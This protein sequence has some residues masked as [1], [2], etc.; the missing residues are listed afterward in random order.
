MRSSSSAITASKASARPSSTGSGSDQCHQPGSGSSSSCAWSHTVTTNSWCP[1]AASRRGSG[2]AQVQP[3]A[4]RR[5]DRSGM[6]RAIDGMRARGRR[7]P[8]GTSCPQCGC[9]LRTRRVVTTHEQHLT[10]G[11]CRRHAEAGERCWHEAD[12][13]AAAVACRHEPLDQSHTFEDVEV[14]R[15]QI[16]R[17]REPSGEL[18]RRAVADCE[19]LHDRQADRFTQRGVDG[20][21]FGHRVDNLRMLHDRPR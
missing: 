13:S 21:T 8:A 1:S 20:R 7:H 10:R 15:E 16:G 18:L 3:G 11:K 5:S 9:Q 12:I 17:H 19:I 14:V 6:D 2:A 4:R